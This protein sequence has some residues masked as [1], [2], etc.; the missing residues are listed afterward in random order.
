MLTSIG[1]MFLVE[2]QS[3]PGSLQTLLVPL[4]SFC[5]YD[6]TFNNIDEASIDT[7]KMM[8][9]G[10]RKIMEISKILRRKFDP[11]T[12]AKKVL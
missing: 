11:V 10:F 2:H 1:R 5:F 12:A 3:V 6:F 9:I 4:C 7:K 8:R